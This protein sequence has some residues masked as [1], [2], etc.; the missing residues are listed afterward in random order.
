MKRPGND[1]EKVGI[2]ATPPVPLLESENRTPECGPECDCGAPPRS[3]KVK[4]MKVVVSLVVLLAVVG[5]IAYKATSAKQTSSK[6]TAQDSSAFSTAPSGKA[7]AGAKPEE[8][9]KSESKT[10]ERTNKI[11]ETIGSMNDLNTVA[12]SQDAV[13]IFVPGA[14]NEP[15]QDLTSEAVL[16]AQKTLTS[17]NVKL[18]LYTLATDSPDYSSISAQAK[19]PGIFV[20]KKGGGSTFVSGE[21]TASKLLQAF[22]QVSSASG[23]CPSGDSSG[24]Q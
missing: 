8:K 24:C 7:V 22:V 9:G 10:P 13:F 3:R 16:A 11:G 15:V 1:N 18:G 14:M 6:N 2:E 5:I 21:V 20:A 4:V 12:S 19:P 23:C 17:N